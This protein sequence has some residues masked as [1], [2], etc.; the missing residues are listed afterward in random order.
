MI[1]SENARRSAWVYVDIKDIDVGSYI[2]KAQALYRRK[3]QDAP[4]LLLFLERPV[5]IHGDGPGSA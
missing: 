2:K 3:T 5:R 4:G 1:R